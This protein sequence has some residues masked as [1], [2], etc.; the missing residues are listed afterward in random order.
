[1]KKYSEFND[2]YLFSMSQNGDD[3]AFH[4]LY[5]RFFPMLYVHAQQKIGDSQDAKDLIQDIFTNL[6]YKKE[7]LGQINNFSGYLYVLLKN[8]I[9]NFI[10][11]KSVRVNYLEK[12]DFNTSIRDVES[13]VFE[14]ELQEQIENGVKFLPEKMRQVFIMS[15]YEHL[16]HKEIG[17]RLDIS[18]KTVK[19]QIVN[20]LK[21]IKSKLHVFF[22]Y[23]F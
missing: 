10:A 17:E 23:F 5:V 20:A 7:E 14:R 3:D 15:R 11:K 13:Y 21:I 1:M 6:Y 4:V 2:E 8:R 16:S 18:D 22:I 9:L 12:L 19:R